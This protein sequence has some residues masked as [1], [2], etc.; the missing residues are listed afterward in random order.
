MP[1][2]PS[3]YRPRGWKPPEVAER[4]AD[5]RRGSASARGYGHTWAKASD[6]HGLANP[7]CAY[8]QLEGRVTLRELTDH[9]YPQQTY[10]GVFWVVGW[11]VS[12]CADCHNG[13]KQRVERAGIAALD[14]LARRLGLPT[15]DEGKGRGWVNL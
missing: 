7:L 5:Q 10:A 14:A 6:A 4:E 9:L 8:C 2:R 1:S 12:C 13:F 3:S 11:W 15:L